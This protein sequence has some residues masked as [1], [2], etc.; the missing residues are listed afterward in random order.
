VPSCVRVNGRRRGRGRVL[1]YDHSCI[2]SDRK[3]AVERLREAYSMLYVCGFCG[4]TMFGRSI[5]GESVVARVGSGDILEFTCPC[6]REGILEG[7]GAAP[8][9][10]RRKRTNLF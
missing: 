2:M 3:T 7:L 6:C 4:V 10:V 8:V 5:P 1:F 9:P